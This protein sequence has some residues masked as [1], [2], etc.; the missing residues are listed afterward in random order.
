MDIAFSFRPTHT[1]ER[2]YYI[3]KIIVFIIWGQY[4]FAHPLNKL[5][6]TLMALTDKSGSPP[7]ISTELAV[8]RM[9][10]WKYPIQS[11][12]APSLMEQLRQQKDSAMLELMAAE[13]I[14]KAAGDASEVEAA[15]RSLAE[16]NAAVHK[17]ECLIK[18]AKLYLQEIREELGKGEYSA[19]IIDQKSTDWTGDEYLTVAS[20]EW[21]ARNKHRVS[22]T[23]P[24]YLPE[25]P[26]E[27]P[28]ES[29][30]AQIT[31]VRFITKQ[32]VMIAFE[33]MHF[34]HEHWGKNLASPPKWLEICRVAKGNKST[35]S[36]WNPVLIAIALY[37]K[38]IPIKKL[39]AVFVRLSVWADEWRDASE[40]FR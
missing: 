21:W 38:R 29:T 13:E 27:Q 14:V 39:D 22:I 18:Q 37:D 25:I 15:T 19:I 7:I 4:F 16:T 11:S 24:D 3:S 10:G 35:A 23:S 36:T 2:I 33:D 5:R 40:H 31:A 30:D 12:T 26:Q 6:E 9:I 17:L 1:D 34:D 20:I 28:N 8:A 32:E